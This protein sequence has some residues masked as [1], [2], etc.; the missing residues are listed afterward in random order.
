MSQPLVSICVP[1]KNGEN[2]K[3]SQQINI[4]KVLNNLV[5]QTYENIEIIVSD[6]CS[7]DRT[8]EIIKNFEKNIIL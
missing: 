1:V 3:N 6:N 4:E 5:N 8:F 7:D 2:I